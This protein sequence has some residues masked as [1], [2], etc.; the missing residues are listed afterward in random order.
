MKKL[1]L[2]KPLAVFD[3]ESTGVNPR[4][5]RI[6]DLAV[7]KLM[8]D[9]SRQ[10]H[11][12]RLNPEIP[13][14]PAASEVHG[15]YDEDVRDCPTFKDHAREIDEVLRGSDLAGFNV[16]RFDIPLLREEF[17]RA[18]VPFVLD[19]R[20]VFDAQRIFHMKEPRDLSAALNF[21]CGEMHLDAHGAMADVLATIR[22]MEGQ[23]ERYDDLPDNMDDM[24]ALCNPRDPDHIDE[25]GRFKWDGDEAVVNFSKYQG[26]PL[27]ELAAEE[28][29]FLRWIVK[30]DFPRDTKE[31]AEAALKGELPKRG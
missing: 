31:I 3:I 2:D 8:P 25:A 27:R 29:G 26:T 30:N 15:I 4:A 20:R 22:V 17:L 11:C 19:G 12:W 9:G 6:I 28:P 14:P 5:D 13:I 21:Y 1:N 16:L 7:V 18:G 10:E 23:Y 24:D